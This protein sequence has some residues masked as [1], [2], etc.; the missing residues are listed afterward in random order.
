MSSLVGREGVLMTRD[1]CLCLSCSLLDVRSPFQ[2]ATSTS[3]CL[4]KPSHLFSCSEQST[5]IALYKISI[6][7]A[8]NWKGE[9]SPLAGNSTTVFVNLPCPCARG[10]YSQEIIYHSVINSNTLFSN[11]MNNSIYK[12]L[13]ILLIL[14]KQKKKGKEKR[15]RKHTLVLQNSY[16]PEG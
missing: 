2:V 11:K 13:K 15:K 14:M 9:L 6:P 7:A 1:V 16:I 3:L 8:K 12:G 10:R 4:E 5:S